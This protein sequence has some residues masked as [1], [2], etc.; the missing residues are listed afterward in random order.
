MCIAR[1][2]SRFMLDCMMRIDGTMED[3]ALVIW[4]YLVMVGRNW[5]LAKKNHL[6]N[7]PRIKNWLN[8]IQGIINNI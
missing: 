3:F 2:A 4:W 6:P 7:R 5:N 8:E 1:E